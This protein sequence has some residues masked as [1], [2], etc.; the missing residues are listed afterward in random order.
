MTVHLYLKIGGFFIYEGKVEAQFF[1]SWMWNLMSRSVNVFEVTA[2]ALGWAGDCISVE[3]GVDKVRTDGGKNKTAM[4]KHL[5]A[6]PFRPSVSFVLF[7]PWAPPMCVTH[8][9]H[10]CAPHMCAT[11]LCHPFAPL[12]CATHLRHPIST[13]Q[14]PLIHEYQ[15]KPLLHECG[16]TLYG[17]PTRSDLCSVSTNQNLSSMNTVT[18]LM[19]RINPVSSIGSERL[20]RLTHQI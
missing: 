5:F 15:S 18:P 1:H 13:N 20:H 3:F 17:Q 4:V 14:K 8:L 2:K 10:P 6:N 7:Q 11:H 19:T 12:I 16:Y 9:R